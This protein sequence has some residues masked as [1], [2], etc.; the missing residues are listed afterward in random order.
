MAPSSTSPS[1]SASSL[2]SSCLADP[3][4]LQ[5]S[6]LVCSIVSLE[7]VEENLGLVVYWEG[8]KGGWCVC[9]GVSCSQYDL[10]AQRQG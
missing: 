8:G 9:G 3:H 2:A 7:R 5:T 6:H 10:G 1:S 4:S